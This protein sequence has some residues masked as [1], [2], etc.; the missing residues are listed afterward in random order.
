MF[1]MYKQTKTDFKRTREPG[2]D[3]F[4][5]HAL[6]FCRILCEFNPYR[7][8]SS[9][10][11]VQLIQEIGAMFLFFLFYTSQNIKLYL[12]TF[13]QHNPFEISLIPAAS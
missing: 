10:Q 5:P 3:H 2:T 8:S 12:Q 9:Y 6:C 4:L 1:K 7:V 13:L 11:N